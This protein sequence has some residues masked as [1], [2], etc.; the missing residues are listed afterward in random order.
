MLHRFPAVVLALVLVPMSA[1]AD[2]FD[3][4]DNTILAKIPASKSAEKIAKLTPEIMVQNSRVLPGITA[5]FIVV[6][7]NDNRFA[8]LLV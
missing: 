1:H 6:K 3:N 7:T 2:A 4:Y 8:K 5:T